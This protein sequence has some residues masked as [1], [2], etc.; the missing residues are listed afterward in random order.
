MAA[1]FTW[2]TYFCFV[3]SLSAAFRKVDLDMVNGRSAYLD[4]AQKLA[5]GSQ[6]RTS[7]TALFCRLRRFEGLISSVKQYSVPLWVPPRPLTAA[8]PPSYR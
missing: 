5:P 4:L 8:F 6:R 7:C 1:S 3:R 2:I